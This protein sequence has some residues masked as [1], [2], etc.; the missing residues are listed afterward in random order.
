MNDYYLPRWQM[1]ID[2][3]LA[4]LKGGPP[5]NR[6]ALEKQWR[7]HD[8]K[9]A[10]TADGDYATK[11]RGDFFIMSRALYKKYAPLAGSSHAPNPSTHY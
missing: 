10:T 2:A 11:P 7:D 5:V 3:T 9:F 1:L 6:T 8:L 4:E